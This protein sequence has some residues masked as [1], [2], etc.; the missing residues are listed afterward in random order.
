MIGR[1][2]GELAALA[3]QQPAAPLADEEAGRR[4]ADPECVDELH[5]EPRLR[6]LGRGLRRCV[7]HPGGDRPVGGHRGDVHDC[8]AR[9]SRAEHLGRQQRSDDAAYRRFTQFK[10]IMG[11][12]GFGASA[13]LT[14]PAQSGATH[15]AIAASRDARRVS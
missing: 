1:F 5:R 12:L 7:A 6:F 10:R 8:A 3:G 9:L 14:W 4:Y 15:P 13:R 2:G 11:D